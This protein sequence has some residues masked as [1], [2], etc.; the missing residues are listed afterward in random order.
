MSAELIIYGAAYGPEDVTATVR[1]LRADQKLSFTVSDKT[2]G[3]DPWHGNE[4]T[5]VIIYKYS[6]DDQVYTKIVVQN[7]ECVINPPSQPPSAPI[8]KDQLDSSDLEAIQQVSSRKMKDSGQSLVILGAAYGKADVTDKANQA[9]T[10]NGEFDEEA[11]NEVWEDSWKGHKKTLVVVYEYDGLQMLN[12]VKENER[13]YFIAS[14]AMTILGAA[15]GLAD[16][17]TKVC[18]LVKNRSLAVT[19]NNDTFGDSWK[20]VKKTLVVTYQYGEQTPVVAY[21]KENDK[22]EIIYNKA[23]D[24][25][26]STNPDTLTILGAA[27][28]PSDVTKKTQDYAVEGNNTVQKE[29]DNDNFGPDPWKTVKSLW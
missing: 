25:T 1:S 17:T 2:F 18:A 23:D 21:A 14:P 16:V 24:Y 10:S 6:T 26:G 27:Y 28:G 3:G 4:K 5:L 19:A 20:G 7:D 29:V 12:V 8:A 15:Y 11:S 9:L 22:L 13:M